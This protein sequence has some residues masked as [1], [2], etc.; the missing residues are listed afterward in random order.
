MDVD[1]MLNALKKMANEDPSLREALM[2]T[3]S[4]ANPLSAFCAIA[5]ERGIMLY[6]MDVMTEGEAA[7]AASQTV[8]AD[9]GA[10]IK[11]STNGGGENS[12]V[13]EGED[14]YYEMFLAGL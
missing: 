7:Y 6:E 11:R 14:D 3:R 4:A 12:P 1:A 8:K 9:T 13:L 5:R 2:A 10:A